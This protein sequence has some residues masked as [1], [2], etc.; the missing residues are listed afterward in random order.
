MVLAG[1][2][3]LRLPGTRSLK[4]KRAR[5]R[6]IVDRVRHRHHLSVAEVDR[7]DELGRAVIEVA[8]V[9][10]S[11]GHATEVLDGIER[12]VWSAE[13]VEVISVERFWLEAD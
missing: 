13:G 2:F 4:D 3:D 8:V 12:L 10:S 1:R 5:I 7:Q 9:A 6:P 11:P